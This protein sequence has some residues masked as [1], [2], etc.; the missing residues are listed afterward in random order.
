[1]SEQNIHKEAYKLAEDQLAQERVDIIKNYILKTLRTIE[2]KKEE[3]S[4]IEEELRVLKLDL[5]DLRSGNFTK[6]KDRQQKSLTAKYTSQVELIPSFDF[7][8]L[9]SP[10]LNWFELTSGTYSFP[11]HNGETKVIYY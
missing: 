7:L 11:L 3:K 5:E 1:M 8:P 6:I 2:N 9:P 4:R 10:I